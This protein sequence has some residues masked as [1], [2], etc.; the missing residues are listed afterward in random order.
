MRDSLKDHIEN[1]R[2]E[3]EVYPFDSDQEWAKVSNKLQPNRKKNFWHIGGMAACFT[4][5]VCGA[6]FFMNADKE[7]TSEVAELESYYNGEINQKITLIKHRL[8]DDEI[9]RDLEEMDEAFAE[10]KGDLK[11]NVDNE[12]VITAMMENYR[13]KL[14]ILE[15]ILNELEKEQSEEML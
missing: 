11:D 4:L 12:E 9:L 8:D 7:N 6:V 5:I 3:F 10:L 1:T 13:L 15:E 14:Q 2:E